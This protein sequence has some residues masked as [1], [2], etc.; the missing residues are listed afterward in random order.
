MLLTESVLRKII[1][2]E[3]EKLKK[4]GWSGRRVAAMRAGGYG[5]FTHSGG[6]TDSDAALQTLYSI[7]SKK[8]DQDMESRPELVQYAKELYTKFVNEFGK[9]TVDKYIQK[10]NLGIIL[11][12]AGVQEAKNWKMQQ[13]E[14]ALRMS[15]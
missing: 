13:R 7:F 14:K 10:H 15:P 2:E 9:E 4:E 11:K 1:A 12:Y 3:F 8:T 5:G 6:A